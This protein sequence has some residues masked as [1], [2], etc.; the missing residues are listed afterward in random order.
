MPLQLGS[1]RLLAFPSPCLSRL[2]NAIALRRR[3]S[4]SI[5]NHG[6][7]SLFHANASEAK[8][9]RSESLRRATFPSQITSALFFAIPLLCFSTRRCAALCLS[10]ALPV[11]ASQCRCAAIV[12]DASPLHSSSPHSLR[13]AT[14]RNAVAHRSTAVRCLCGSVP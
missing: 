5:A 14:L 10:F 2:L 11:C 4:C 7:F 6:I 9:C 12:R 3:P 13:F 1:L 8:P